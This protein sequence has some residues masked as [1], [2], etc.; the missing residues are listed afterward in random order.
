M[1]R[2]WVEDGGEHTAV[3]LFLVFFSRIFAFLANCSLQ[4][5]HVGMSRT[6]FYFAIRRHFSDSLRDLPSHFGKPSLDNLKCKIEK[7][8]RTYGNFVTICVANTFLTV[9]ARLANL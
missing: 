9:S 1:E 8:R 7:S 4:K 5:K 6:L 2:T 3:L